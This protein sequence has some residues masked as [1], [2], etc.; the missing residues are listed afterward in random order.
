[1]AVSAVGVL[2]AVLV[3]TGCSSHEPA[4][5]ARP[6]RPL[7]VS[8]SAVMAATDEGL[9]AGCRDAARILRFAVPCPTML[10]ATTGPVRCRVPAAAAGAE[11][12][13]KR[14]CALAEG[15][16]LEPTGMTDPAIRHLV[17]EGSASGFQ[18][19]CGKRDPH[20][21]V[22]VHGRLA[23]L[24]DCSEL[25]GLHAGHAALIWREGSTYVTV[26]LHGHTEENRRAVRAIADGIELVPGGGS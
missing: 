4:R 9:H 18:L 6:E 8:P 10:P 22:T 1:M 16:I 24:V 20:T 25:A 5:D 14:G 17:I 13:P 15:F 2:I 21:Q 23:L 26:S 3:L 12:R 11:V 7:H 19:D